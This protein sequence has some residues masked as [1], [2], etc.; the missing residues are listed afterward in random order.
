M[1]PLADYMDY[2]DTT[3]MLPV[4]E[5]PAAGQVAREILQKMAGATV[6]VVYKGDANK[7]G[8]GFSDPRMRMVEQTS[9]GGKGAGV[10]DALPLVHTDIVCL[11]DG[12]ATYSVDDLPKVVEMARGGVDVA[13]GNRF[14]S[15]D[16]KA[17]PFFI[18]F[19]NKVITATANLLYGMHIHDSQTGLRALR[20]SSLDRLNLRENGFGIESEIN[21]RARKAGMRIEETPIGYSVRVGSSKQMKLLDGI[22]LLLLD[23][24]FLL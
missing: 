8:I 12:D 20:K 24:K 3:V 1:L 5:E 6:L 7:L 17:M 13:L 11:I 21:I 9:T 19:G 16:R 23:F 18:E 10:R 15:L 14:A 2:S 22:K 4:K